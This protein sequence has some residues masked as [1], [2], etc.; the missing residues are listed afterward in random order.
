MPARPLHPS[1]TGSATPPAGRGGAGRR[2]GGRRRPPAASPAWGAP[3]PSNSAPPGRRP[4]QSPPPRHHS[5]APG[6]GTGPGPY[7]PGTSHSMDS[8]RFR[9]DAASPR[10]PAPW[11]SS[12]SRIAS[13]T[14]MPTMPLPRPSPYGARGG[15]P[16]GMV[17]FGPLRD[18]HP[19]GSGAAGRPARPLFWRQK[20][21]ACR[22]GGGLN[23]PVGQPRTV[24]TQPPPRSRPDF[25][26][27]WAS[28]SC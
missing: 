16:P 5:G 18:R 19:A 7:A 22:M 12:A 8:S 1:G 26:V 28:R 2:P 11:S 13:P 15:M 23:A 14:D 4:P 20:R 10:R 3:P 9:A 17:A 25:G 27:M 6:R 24:H 21:P